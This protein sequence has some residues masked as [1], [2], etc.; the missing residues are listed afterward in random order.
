[1][2]LG[3]II[4]ILWGIPHQMFF[5]CGSTR[6]HGI[7]TFCS[8]QCVTHVLHGHD[9]GTHWQKQPII[10][11][12]EDKR[13]QHNLQSRGQAKNHR[14]HIYEGKIRLLWASVLFMVFQ[15]SLEFLYFSW[16]FKTPLSFCTFHVF[17]FKASISFC[18]FYG[19]LKLP[20]VSVLFRVF[21][22]YFVS[23]LFMVF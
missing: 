15:D 19:V 20:S 17:F 8:D 22:T 13:A 4:S 16:C 10:T 11:E 21:K 6:L 1:M 2:A 7:D 12:K 5:G 3:T 14:G 23:V 9:V 18:T